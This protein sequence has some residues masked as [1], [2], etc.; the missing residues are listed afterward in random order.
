MNKRVV[1]IKN[2]DSG[3]IS[4]LQVCDDVCSFINEM[5]AVVKDKPCAYNMFPSKYQFVVFGIGAE[6]S[7]IEFEDGHNE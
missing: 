4:A 2:K 1:G 6:L 3:Y 5:R 7:T